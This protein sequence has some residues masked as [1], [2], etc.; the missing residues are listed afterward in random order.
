MK[1][2]YESPQ[3]SEDFLTITEAQAAEEYFPEPLNGTLGCLNQEFYCGCSGS[4]QS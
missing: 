4:Q 3:I 2:K 1:R